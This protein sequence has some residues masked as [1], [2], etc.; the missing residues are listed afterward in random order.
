M[1]RSPRPL[2]RRSL[3][4]SPYLL[5]ALAGAA[6]LAAGCGG[7]TTDTRG[8][9]LTEGKAKFIEKCGGC[10][11]LAAAGTNGT[12]G[13][14]L[15]WAFRASREQG[16]DDSTF[17]EVVL[18]QMKI[19]GNG[20]PMPEFHDKA[21][22]ANYL[23]DQQ[24][25]NVAAYVAAVAGTGETADLGDPKALF[26]ANCGSCHTL[27]DAGTTGTTGP[28]LD[29]AKPTLEKALAQIKAGGG[30]M[31]AFE[32]TLTAE[33]IQALAEYLVGATGGR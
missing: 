27:A 7:Q 17:F 33:Q 22:A 26:T 2:R 25:T 16:F 21:D 3:S 10:H 14:N 6:V 13:P 28:N 29:D 30:G 4:R 8:A 5:A 1:R 19:P 12:T 31:P 32:G 11:T 20:S 18:E 23:T 15:D 9:D 24:L